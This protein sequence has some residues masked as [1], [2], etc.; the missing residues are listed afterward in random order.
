MEKTILKQARFQAMIFPILDVLLNGGNLLIHIYISWYLTTG[1]YGILN[2][3]FSLLFVLMILGM[4]MQTYLAKRISESDF[5]REDISK[6]N[7]V[8][9]FMIIVVLILMMLFSG[10]TINLLRGTPVQYMLILS[11]FVVQVR[12]S[13][14]R[15]VLQGS[16]A[17]FKLNISF[18]VEMGFKLLVLIPLIQV[19][20]SVEAALVSVLLGMTASYIT[21]RR[22][23]WK[24]KFEGRMKRGKSIILLRQLLSDHVYM[25]ITK[26]FLNVL[27]TQIF[28]YY[29]TAVVLILTNYYMGEA[30]GLYAVSTRYGQIFIHVGL[31][32]ITVLIPYTSEVKNDY[33]TFKRKVTRLLGVY[34][35]IAVFMFAGY[36]MIMPLALKYLFDSSY[37]GA[38]ELLI[39]QAF[40]YVM[41][42]I[43]FYISSMEMVAGYKDY[44]GTL[45]VFSFILLICLLL[46]HSSL[47]QIVIIE[48]VVYTTM[49]S[50]LIG[51]FLT[52]RERKC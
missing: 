17:F 9:N 22:S 50:V 51:R 35:G 52:R 49:A 6:I 36:S 3:Y 31:S 28:F 43:S 11:T 25:R 37:H 34:A 27:S 30:S 48:L 13:L 15:G 47:I 33:L 19:A 44:I 26:G 42:S 20:R 16:K 39:P 18:Y 10:P 2:A 40:A 23:V 24:L 8:T 29:F 5:K 46:W 32:I 38:E 12:L 7:L 41:L 4:S 21:T 45:T 1:D 14:Y